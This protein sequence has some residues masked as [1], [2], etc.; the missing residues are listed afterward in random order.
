MVNDTNLQFIREKVCELR[1]AIMYVTSNGLVK[2]GNDIVTALKVD[3]EGQLWFIT[4]R[5]THAEECEESFPAR[6]LFYKKGV[7]FFLEVS[8][9]ATIVST[10]Y[11]SQG[12]GEPRGCKV[13]VKMGMT[14][15][16]YTEPHTRKPKK[17]IEV[18]AE[19]CYDWFLRTISV[20]H[21]S[22]SVLKRLRQ[23]N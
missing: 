18:I 3:D 14:N 7:N 1:S 15:I 13:L 21:N 12:K 11:F 10:T 19:N 6:L 22:D 2:L 8:G 23:T 4:N 20:P 5:P 17:K 16:E 9:K